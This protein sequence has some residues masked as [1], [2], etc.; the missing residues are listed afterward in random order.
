MITLCSGPTITP[1][2]V[3]SALVSLGNEAFSHMLGAPNDLCTPTYTT[4]DMK[5]VVMDW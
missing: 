1:I 5:N 4:P 2:V 3:N